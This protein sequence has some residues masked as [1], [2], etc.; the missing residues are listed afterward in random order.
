VP[1]RPSPRCRDG[2]ASIEFVALVPV[3]VLLSVLVLQGVLVGGTVWF[4]GG[5]ARDAARAH[6]IGADPL[7]AAR[8]TLPRALAAG[9]EV[10]VADGDEVEVR[11]RVPSLTGLDLGT[12]AATAHLAV[13]R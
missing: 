7:R 12:V 4:V 11:L 1:V 2:Q 9:A 10:R 6:A 8:A 3:L 13:Q 5:A